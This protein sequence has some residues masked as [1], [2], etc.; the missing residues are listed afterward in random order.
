[1][2]GDHAIQ[3]R[4]QIAPFGLQRQLGTVNLVLQRRLIMRRSQKGSIKTRI[5][6]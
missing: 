4:P 5:R 3:D 1:M 2:K 6:G